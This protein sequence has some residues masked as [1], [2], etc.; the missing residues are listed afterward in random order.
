MKIVRINLLNQYEVVI[1]SNLI[2]QISTIFDLSKYSKVVVLTDSN[3]EP[4]YFQNLKNS[5][6]NQ[7]EKIVTNPGEQNKNIETVQLIWR[8]L[9]ELGCDRKSLLINL[10]GG[11]IGDMGGFAAT[12]F[13]RGID[14]LQIPTTLLSQV[15]SS[16]GGKVGINFN[17][18]KNLIGAF[19]QPIGVLCDIA[20]LKSLGEREFVE[21]F[22]EVIKHGI[23]ADKEYFNFV[24]S[25]APLDFSLQEL[26]E[27]VKKSCEIKK[28]IIEEDVTEK[29]RRRLVN[30]G[31]TIGHALES[32]SLEGNKSLLH[33]E[34]VSIGMVAE[35][36]IS[37]LL[38]MLKD[39]EIEK[40]I[41]ALENAGLPIR[42]GITNVTKVL[43]IIYLDK[44]SEKGVIK[45]TLIKGIG[46]GVYNQIVKEEDIIKVLSKL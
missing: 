33:G 43:K 37:Q 25:K 44:K 2:D 29:D 15:D 45:W 38:G 8:R 40:I 5:I 26:V 4:L 42:Y 18:V 7:V 23:I 3:L 10:G 9:L 36:K 46:K 6:S 28:N 30:F 31:H 14:F 22:G 13:M 20:L 11:V 17:G 24:T 27:I 41:R 35:A 19:N 39:E 12:T 32:L 34:A 21:G 1:G 16:I